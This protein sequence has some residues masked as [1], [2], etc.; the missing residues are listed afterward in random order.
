MDDRRRPW[1]MRAHPLP[2]LVAFALG[3][4]V[5]GGAT[6][7]G[8]LITGAD[9]KNNSLTGADVRNGSL[10]GADIR[11]RSV[12]AADLSS[13][14]RAA[15][16]GPAGPVGPVGPSGAAGAQGPQGP[17]GPTGPAALP[18][19]LTASFEGFEEVGTS[20]ETIVSRAVPEGSYL[21]LATVGLQVQP[22]SVTSCRLTAGGVVLHSQAAP[23][24]AGFVISGGVNLMAVTPAGTSF[25]AV[26]CGTGGGTGDVLNANLIATPI[27]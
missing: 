13:A 25:I 8:D 19:P 21:V 1:S 5:V 14:A 2:L 20:H 23:N 6:A 12:G 17:A 7:A 27:T 26:T 22:S 9:V 15:L 10:T 11:N 24:S 3:A 4:A 16:R 18:Q